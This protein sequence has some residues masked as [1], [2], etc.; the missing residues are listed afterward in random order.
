MRSQSRSV[1]LLIAAAVIATA[2]ARE[3]ALD[4]LLS[5]RGAPEALEAAIVAAREAGIGEQGILEAR[6]LF[7][8]DRR[9][10]A[11]IAA[12]APEFLKRRDAF[13]V[14]DSEIFATREDFLAVS[15]Y[16]QALAALE[17]DDR[18]AFKTHIT[19]AF[20]LSP[21][22]GAAFAPHIDRLRLADAMREVRIDYSIRL[23]SLNG[24]D[25]VTLE[26]FNSEAPAT[27][28]HFWS[29]WSR[30]CEVTMPDFFAT[31]IELVKH[32][33]AVVSILP[34]QSED[35]RNDARELIAPLGPNPPG[36]WL[37]DRPK[38]PLS[39]K[40]RVQSV[41]T[42]VLLD[43]AGAVL[44]NGH[45]ADEALWTAIASAAPDAARPAS[46]DVGER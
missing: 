5:E 17:R 10:D 26:S 14:E 11:A 21:R 24:G 1:V 19:E 45:P 23:A 2:G 9:E 44:F 20:W 36:H 41:P 43:R 29:P 37:I 28:L 12:L 39:R 13:R 25:P 32:N 8:V 30:E 42:M 4:N 33:I 34:E 38:D 22:Q 35:V 7:H 15:E 27:L 31:A 46:P 40:L 3:E 18:D 16:V 6:F